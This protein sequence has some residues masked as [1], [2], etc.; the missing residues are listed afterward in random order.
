MGAR[1]LLPRFLAVGASDEPDP[2]FT[3]QIQ[4]KKEEI[5]MSIDSPIGGYE[6]TTCSSGDCFVSDGAVASPGLARGE[7][8]DAETRIGI[9]AP[10][11]AVRS[12]SANEVVVTETRGIDT[13]MAIDLTSP[14]V[15]EEA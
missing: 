1:L 15:V 4:P 8:A 10:T 13:P 12:T 2:K 11:P 14:G 9:D 6:S 7:Q 3:I 5:A